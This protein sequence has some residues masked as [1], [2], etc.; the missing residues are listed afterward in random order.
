MKPLPQHG[1]GDRAT[2]VRRLGF[3]ASGAHGHA[4]AKPELTEK[5]IIHAYELGVRL[6]DTAPSY[7]D[8]EAERR[9]GAAVL[10]LPRLELTICTKAGV[11]SDGATRK[12]RDFSADAIRRSLDAS[13]ARLKL[14]R[15]DWLFLHGPAPEE[16]TDRLLAALEEERF[17]GRVVSI[18]VAGR[19]PEVEAAMTTGAFAGAMVPVR[20][21]MSVEERRRIADLAAR[22]VEIFGIETMAAALARFPPPVSPGAAWRLAR[23]LAGRARGV[24]RQKLR[25]EQALAWA[26]REGGAHRV[27]ATT[28]RL[29]HLE[30]NVAAVAAA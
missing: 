27:I 19:G 10:R 8:G 3:G 12:V 14:S 13:L 25:P 6:F 20:P 9:L 30:R 17:A 15:V 2:G 24:E 28:S 1:A 23:A 18:G 7:G 21:G 11:N 29:R 16:L 4:L 22:R 26:L 5:L